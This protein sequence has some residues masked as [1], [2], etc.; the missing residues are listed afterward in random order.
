MEPRP[1]S[2]DEQLLDGAGEKIPSSSEK[3][4]S[5]LA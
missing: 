5:P 2:L 4:P 3:L 1:V